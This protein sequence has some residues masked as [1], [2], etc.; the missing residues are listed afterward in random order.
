MYDGHSD[1]ERIWVRSVKKRDQACN[2]TEITDPKPNILEK[3]T[4]PAFGD[5][6]DTEDPAY[7]RACFNT[8]VMEFSSLLSIH[9]GVTKT[10][11][12]HISTVGPPGF[13]CEEDR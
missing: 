11:T 1:Q 12:H 9:L 13:T 8:V 10:V 3:G 2:V 6:T 5:H 7:V 4:L